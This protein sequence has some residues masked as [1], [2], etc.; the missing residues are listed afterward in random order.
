MTETSSQIVSALIMLTLKT[1]PKIMSFTH[2]RIL[3]GEKKK[4]L[5]L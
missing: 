4:N 1:F 5:I 3:W 2:I